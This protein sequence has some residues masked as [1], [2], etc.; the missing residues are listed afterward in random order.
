MTHFNNINVDLDGGML[1]AA[2][3]GGNDEFYFPA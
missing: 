3:G 1:G 2:W